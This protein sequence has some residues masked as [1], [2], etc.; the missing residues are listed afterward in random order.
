MSAKDRISGKLFRLRSGN[1]DVIELEDG[2]SAG[3]GPR[4]EP[5]D[6]QFYVVDPADVTKKVRFDAGGVTTATTRVVTMADRD[7][8]LGGT[9]GQ[10]RSVYATGGAYATPVVLTANDSGKTILLDTAAGL[11]FTLPAITSSNTGI[12]FR[13]YVTTT[14]T[15]NN[16][17]FTAQ[18]GDLLLGN[19]L[20][21]D[22]D[23]ATGD[24]N[25]LFSV[26][27][28]N[29]SSHLVVT[30]GGSADTSG[31]LQGGWLELEAITATAWFVRGILIGDGA[32][33]TVFS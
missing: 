12:H 6:D 3:S 30:I 28:P 23:A 33:A 19:V 9:G 11:D 8:D 26:F 29:G 13:F 32:L 16:Y 14:L 18:S 20:I 1:Q 2:A 24:A 10:V 21:I 17:R 5:R 15:S 27:R 25:A 4:F 7:L 31:R 22:K